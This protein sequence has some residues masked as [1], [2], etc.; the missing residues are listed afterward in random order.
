MPFRQLLRHPQRKIRYIPPR[1]DG[2]LLKAWRAAG[3][4]ICGR[5]VLA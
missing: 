1:R 2:G 5:P 3:L 4:P